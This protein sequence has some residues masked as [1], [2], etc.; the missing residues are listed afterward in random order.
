[1][2]HR[3]SSAFRIGSTLSLIALL[4][5]A[6]RGLTQTIALADSA[7]PLVTMPNFTAQGH[8]QDLAQDQ[9]LPDSP[10]AFS[11]QERSNLTPE[12]L[13]AS[14]AGNQP[15]HRERF[16]DYLRT[17]YRQRAFSPGAPDGWGQD[18]TGLSQST[19]PSAFVGGNDDRTESAMGYIPCRGCSVRR[20]LAN[21]L[22]GDKTPHRGFNSGIPGHSIPN[23]A[24]GFGYPNRS[25]AG[26][27]ESARTMAAARVGQH[28]FTEFVSDRLHHD[29]KPGN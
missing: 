18:S 21:A 25:S 27:I 9:E 2:Q 24:G 6:N 4:G 22:L 16:H 19:M 23:G 1:M 28:L 3:L 14:R 7:G 13:A 26:G 11:S 8:V 12:E 10:S 20:K 29:L 5:L 17:S 15:S